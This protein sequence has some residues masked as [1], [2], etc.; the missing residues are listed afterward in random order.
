MVK[1]YTAKQKAATVARM[2][3]QAGTAAYK[4]RAGPTIRG[5]KKRKMSPTLN[6]QK[7]KKK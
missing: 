2:R 4:K 7:R 1:K 5:S 3:K 6:M